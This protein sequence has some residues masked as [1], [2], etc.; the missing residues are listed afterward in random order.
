MEQVKER[1]LKELGPSL[2]ATNRQR[3]ER[4]MTQMLQLWRP[5]DGDTQAFESIVRQ[6]LVTQ[7]D[8]RMLLFNR[9]EQNLEQLDGHFQEISRKLREPL[10]LDMGATLPCDDLFA[11]YNPSAHVL[12]DWFKNKLAFVA[13][14][15]FPW[16][17]LEE[18]LQKG[19]QWTREEWAE[20]R[21]GQRFS[22]RVP[23]EVTLDISRIE[24]AANRYVAEYN[25][26]MHHVLETD[27]T[28]LFPEKMR[29]L[30]HWNLRDEIKACYGDPQKGLAKQRTIQQV[31]ER[32][33]T[34]TIPVSV[35]NHSTVDWDPRSNIVAITAAKD[36]DDE[37]LTQA[38][39]PSNTPEPDT[40][41]ATILSTFH[42]M[43]QL[44]PWV[45]ALPTHIAR[46]F[47]DDRELSEER[48]RQMLE[49]I[50]TS[51]EVPRV[52]NLIKQ[53][54]NRPLEPFDI[55]Y[56]GF[57]PNAEYNEAELDAI[58]RA[59]Y[60]SAARF[61]QEIPRILRRLG[62]SR[63]RIPML[64]SHIA[65][66]ASRGSGHAMGASMRDA[67]A[68]LR[69]RIDAG[70]MNYKGYNIALHE[71]GHNVEQVLSLNGVDHTL[72]QSVPNNAFTE[73]FAFVFQSRD[74]ELLDLHPKAGN[75]DHLKTLSDFWGT[76][77]ISGVALVDMEMWRWMYAHPDA[78]PGELKAAVLD[79]SRRIW[80]Q[81]YAGVFQQR[82]VVLLGIYS[83][84]IDNFMY[85]PDYPIGH[86]I[87]QQIEQQMRKAGSVGKEFERM[88][89]VGRVSPDLWMEKATGRPVSAKPM[90]EGV[91]QALDQMESKR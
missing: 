77:E 69:T 85:L 35:I 67:K 59:K 66:D 79:I 36:L 12:D 53:R 84:M 43:R 8:A 15:N 4:G 45:P 81:Y 63:D 30:P 46:R 76:Y 54:L 86:L 56:N 18:R 72:L 19:P 21:L 55:W 80:N 13:V 28:R 78:S 23:S 71:L 68:R 6:H 91:K 7:R 37:S 3:F 47:D 62:F 65:V 74:L 31:M 26:Y 44:D 27:G 10:D 70:G 32:I 50:L 38:K 29:L 48:V 40:R 14:L 73:A 90:L 87:A 51:P 83:H 17:T 75:Q 41:Y 39:A 58:V 2:D 25:I 60:P 34:Q 61:E 88:A 89:T 42:A 9:F 82:D 57:R 33:V 22:R 49:T 64:A 52:A 11:A 20:A 16:T 1:L 24:A 5:S